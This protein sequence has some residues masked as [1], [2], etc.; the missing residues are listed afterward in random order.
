MFV[1]FKIHFEF[2]DYKVKCDILLQQC[3]LHS[4]IQTN[5]TNS[6]R[7]VEAVLWIIPIFHVLVDQNFT[8]NVSHVYMH[9]HLLN[10]H[11]YLFFPVSV[12]FSRCCCGEAIRVHQN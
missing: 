2:I 8:T 6:Y 5:I 1:R 12:S 3:N 11:V 4:F 10:I 9:S 7:T